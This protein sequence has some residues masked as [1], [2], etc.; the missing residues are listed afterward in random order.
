M[1]I[2]A[3]CDVTTDVMSHKC[4]VTTMSHK[5]KCDV[6]IYDVKIANCKLATE[7]VVAKHW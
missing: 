1:C 7:I 4:D 6:K 5:F 2:I 3:L